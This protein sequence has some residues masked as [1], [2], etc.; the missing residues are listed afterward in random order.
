MNMIYDRL[1][2]LCG[3]LLLATDAELSRVVYR[4]KASQDITLEDDLSIR[5]DCELE[6]LYLPDR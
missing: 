6:D 4:N 2:D 3:K 5:I 1:E